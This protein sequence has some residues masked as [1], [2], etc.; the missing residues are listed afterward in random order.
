REPL[1][2]VFKFH[3]NVGHP[4]VYDFLADLFVQP[5]TAILDRLGIDFGSSPWELVFLVL[6]SLIWGAGIAAI[7]SMTR[8]RP[9][10]ATPLV[11]SF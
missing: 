5:L 8:H 9:T 11:K 3:L 1:L 7:I 4:H 2:L 6:N 10:Q